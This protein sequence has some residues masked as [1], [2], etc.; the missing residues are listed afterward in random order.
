MRLLEEENEQI[1]ALWEKPC[2]LYL[3]AVKS[4]SD[5]VAKVELEL[6]GAAHTLSQTVF[7]ARLGDFFAEIAVVAGLFNRG[8]HDF[9]PLIPPQIKKG[10]TLSAPDYRC[11]VPL[12]ALESENFTVGDIAYLEVKNLR[13]PVGITDAF[14]QAYTRLSSVNPDLRRFRFSLGHYWD[15]TASDEQIE[16]INNFLI[17]FSERPVAKRMRLSLP[18][19]VEVE[20]QAIEEPGGVSMMR[21]IGGDHPWGPFT[22][23]ERFFSKA[24]SKIQQGIGQLSSCPSSTRI[25]ALNIQTPDAVFPAD[26]GIRLQKIVRH[27]S[28]GTVE[29]ILFSFN[30]YI[31]T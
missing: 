5:A 20:V 8:F 25:L 28:N 31:D 21:A 16:A 30:H 4:A 15:N 13:A 22:K 12:A 23:D 29:C 11:T 7:D 17:E 2:G 1:L 10:K 6:T 18:E 3:H 26:Y 24:T 19:G 14:A 27:E 9:V